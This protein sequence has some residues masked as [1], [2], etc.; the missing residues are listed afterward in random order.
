MFLLDNGGHLIPFGFHVS[1]QLELGPSTVQVM[2]LTVDSEVMVTVDVVGQETQTAFQSHQ[3][4]THG[5]HF[6]LHGSQ[7]GTGGEEAP[8]VDT[9]HIKIHAD[10]IIHLKSRLNGMLSEYTGQPL[11]QVM[12][13]TERD[14]YMTAAQAKE[15]G[16]IDA[17]I[18]HR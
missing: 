5:K 10:H 16:L 15:Y 13:D 7:V 2:A 17:V 18:D 8:G 14:N 9:E 3:L 11:E 6:N 1:N 4:G 12:Q